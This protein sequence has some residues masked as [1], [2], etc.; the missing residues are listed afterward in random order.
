M[1][2]CTPYAEKAILKDL[3][4][5]GVEG[6]DPRHVE[7]YMRLEHG[8]LDALSS[9]EWTREVVRAVVLIAADPDGAERLARSQ[10]L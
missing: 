10:G 6:V 3:E 7:A 2:G 4:L 9:R 8:T 5:L 1:M